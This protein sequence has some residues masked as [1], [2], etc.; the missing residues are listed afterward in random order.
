MVGISKLFPSNC[1]SE[2]PVSLTTPLTIIPNS[3]KMYSY[4]FS[5]EVYLKAENGVIL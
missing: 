4:V 2:A 5:F 1:A 3:S